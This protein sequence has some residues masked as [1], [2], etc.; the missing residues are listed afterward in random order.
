MSNHDDDP[1]T[2]NPAALASRI[3]RIMVEEFGTAPCRS[4]FV[5]ALA[6]YLTVVCDDNE[7]P[8]KIAADL[9]EAGPTVEPV[10]RQEPTAPP[11]LH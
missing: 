4:C 1:D 2:H 7:I 3:S 5:A 11:R 10:R 8:R 9:V 6:S